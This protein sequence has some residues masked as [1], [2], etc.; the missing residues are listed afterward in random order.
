MFWLTAATPARTGS[1]QLSFDFDRTGKF[2]GTRVAG[3]TPM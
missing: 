3:V 1:M 2:L